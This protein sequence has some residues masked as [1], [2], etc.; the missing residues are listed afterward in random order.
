M[1]RVLFL[2]GL[3]S[4]VGCGTSV[5]Q[6]DTSTVDV[7]ASA[8]GPDGRPL[9]KSLVIVLQPIGDTL[10]ARL[11]ATTDGAFSGKAAPGRYIYFVKAAKSDVPPKGFAAKY[12]EPTQENVVEVAAGKALDLKFGN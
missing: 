5:T 8:S 10:G 9:S 1:T 7:T 3:A 4:L 6:R 12:T 11:E 2:L